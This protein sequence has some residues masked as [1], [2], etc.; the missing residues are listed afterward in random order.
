VKTFVITMLILCAASLT[1]LAASIDGKWIS[2]RGVGAADGK[3]YI[4][5][6]TLNLKTEGG[7]AD[8][9]SRASLRN[10]VDGRDQ[11]P[12]V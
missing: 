3:T 6:T 2:E 11:W 8:G 4:H 5:T 1:A 7:F 12:V 10:A 9:D